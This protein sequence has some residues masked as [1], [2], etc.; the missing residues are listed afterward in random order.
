VNDDRAFG[1]C[2]PDLLAAL[3][4]PQTSMFR[5][6]TNGVLY[7]S[8]GFVSTGGGQAWFEQAVLF[9][10]FCGVLIQTREEVASRSS[11]IQ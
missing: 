10:P 7:L 9:C 2:C 8:V 5:V 4:Q 11:T 3:K 1:S 6:E